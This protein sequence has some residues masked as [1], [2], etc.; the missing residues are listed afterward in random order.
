MPMCL[1][2]KKIQGRSTVKL[3]TVDPLTSQVSSLLAGE[4]YFFATCSFIFEPPFDVLPFGEA[5]GA[6]R[7]SIESAM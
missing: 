1:T 7:V 5:G 6:E 3:K 4:Q 2:Q